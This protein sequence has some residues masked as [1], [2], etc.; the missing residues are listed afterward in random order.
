MDILNFIEQSLLP[1]LHRLK[2]SNLNLSWK[3]FLMPHFH[4]D[5][6]SATLPLSFIQVN[7]NLANIFW[8]LY[9]IILPIC[10]FVYMFICV[11]PSYHSRK[12]WCGI[13][14]LLNLK[15]ILIKNTCGSF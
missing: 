14:G 2:I 1:L 10:S 15:Q 9:F 5:I 8:D 13:I 7:R 6:H 12:I 4:L 3:D 11:H